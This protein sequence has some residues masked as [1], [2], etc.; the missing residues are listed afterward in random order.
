VR[1]RLQ[2]WAVERAEIVW[3]GEGE[4]TLAGENVLARPVGF[5]VIEYVWQDLVRRLSA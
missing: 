4:A 1:G 3:T 5:E 2:I